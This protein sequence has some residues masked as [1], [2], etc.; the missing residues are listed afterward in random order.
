MLDLLELTAQDL[1]HTGA[2]GS[3]VRVKGAGHNIQ[4]TRP[5]AVLSTI[6]TAWSAA[7]TR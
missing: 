3:Y 7:L 6:D 4:V 5:E 1:A 2:R